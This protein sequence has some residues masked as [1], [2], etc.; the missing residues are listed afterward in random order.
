MWKSIVLMVMFMLALAVII[1]KTK[2]IAE[3]P[4]PCA[5]ECKGDDCEVKVFDGAVCVLGPDEYSCCVTTNT[6]AV[7]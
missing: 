1:A 6:R 5:C 4:V 7:S 3:P 2:E